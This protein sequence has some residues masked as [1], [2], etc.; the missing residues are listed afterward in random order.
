MSVRKHDAAGGVGDGGVLTIASLGAVPNG[1]GGSI[2]GTVLTLQPADGTNPGLLTAGAQT[3]G[4][5]K[6]FSGA[7]SASNLS[8]TNTG[9]VTLA[10]V[11]SAPAAEGASL[12]GQ[13]LTLQPADASNPGVV[14]TG[15]QT[16]A[17]VKSWSGVA[18]FSDGS[19]GTPSICG[20]ND[21][22]T[23]FYW[24]TG[25]TMSIV[26][27][28][29]DRIIIG[30]SIN[31]AVGTVN[32]SGGA[33]A[34]STSAGIQAASGSAAAT[35][36]QL[37]TAIRTANVIGIT[38]DPAHGPA[39]RVGTS[40]TDAASGHTSAKLLAIAT[41]V[42]G[43]PVDKA[44]FHGSGRIHFDGT[45]SSG[46]PGNVT[47]NKPSGRF[48]IANGAATVTVTNSLVDVDTDVIVEVL[49]QQAGWFK[50]SVVPGSGSFVVTMN[51][52]A[53]ADRTLCFFLVK[54]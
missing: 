14:T 41:D 27:G 6:T 16:I 35:L 13:V 5:A 30:S 25:N 52:N 31:L 39:V 47:I 12:S 45:D 37:Q 53:S 7:I 18:K 10:A 11:G 24:W 29:V 50:E 49:E 4:G 40:V 36:Q 17:G 28:G 23:G 46:T 44:W 3:I 33:I 2:S 20:I 15:A 1:A 38:S 51:G 26:A 9:N 43:T 21:T 48:A 34:I 22:D 19:A 32:I 8:G 54:R 42:D